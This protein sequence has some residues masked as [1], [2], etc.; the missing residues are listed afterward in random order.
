MFF[1]SPKNHWLKAITVLEIPTMKNDNKIQVVTGK[2]KALFVRVPE[3]KA[4][5]Y[6][7]IARAEG[8]GNLSAWVISTLNK[9]AD[10]KYERR[11]QQSLWLPRQQWMTGPIPNKKSLGLFLCDHNWFRL[12]SCRIEKWNGEWVAPHSPSNASANIVLGWKTA[13]K[14][15][16]PNTIHPTLCQGEPTTRRCAYVR[17]HLNIT[18]SVF[19]LNI[20]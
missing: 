19:L 4:K 7:E 14:R 9:E 5:L 12:N 3:A 6:E 18:I 17:L 10:Y 2:R 13:C 15:F 11:F 1:G 20:Y 16:Y 8:F